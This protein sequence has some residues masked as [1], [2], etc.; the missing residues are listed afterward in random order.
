MWKMEQMCKMENVSN[1]LGVAIPIIDIYPRCLDLILIKLAQ[2]LAV[3][4]FGNCL[5]QEECSTIS[6]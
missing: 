5:K 6:G 4:P 1:D 2:T 3:C